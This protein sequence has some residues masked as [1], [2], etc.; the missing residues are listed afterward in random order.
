MSETIAFET[1]DGIQIV[2][3][4]N[5]L[6]VGGGKTVES[7]AF[8]REANATAY[9]AGD[10]VS[11][12]AATV[13]PAMAFTT[14]GR[15]TGGS[16]YIVGAKLIYNVKSVIPRTRV[17]VFNINTATVA[18]DNLPWKELYADSSKRV[19]YFD[20]P[21]MVTAT[22]TTNSDMSRAIAFDFRLPYVCAAGSTT[23]YV[24]L[25][26]LD[27][28]TLSSGSAATLTLMFEQD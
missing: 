22:D 12:T 18:G 19:G 6:P 14:A 28:V 21:A 24:V 7:Q 23:L 17:H 10:V 11:V 5:M 27:V 4:K 26:T 20:L 16:G 8:T 3:K 9:T 2:S 15:V 13:V 1:A 25:E